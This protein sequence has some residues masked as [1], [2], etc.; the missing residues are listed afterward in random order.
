MYI[1]NKEKTMK[2]M[3]IKVVG[4]NICRLVCANDISK[5]YYY[6]Q[7][8]TPKL[9]KYYSRPPSEKDSSETDLTQEDFSMDDHSLQ[10]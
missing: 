3:Y 10:H 6:K 4:N 2:R 9:P 8:E 7:K 1:I 5:M